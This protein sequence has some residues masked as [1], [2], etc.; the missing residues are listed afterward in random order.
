MGL[1]SPLL[2][3]LKTQ[4]PVLG[5]RLLDCFSAPL[6]GVAKCCKLSC[7]RKLGRVWVYMRAIDERWGGLQGPVAGESGAIADFGLRSSDW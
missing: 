7:G 4:L 6:V 5:S 2:Y 3:R 1:L